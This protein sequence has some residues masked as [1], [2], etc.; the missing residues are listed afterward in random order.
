MYKI[1]ILLVIWLYFFMYLYYNINID[2]T[3]IETPK[4]INVEIINEEIIT[5]TIIKKNIET[6]YIVIKILL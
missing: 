3:A 6:L 1:T 4:T 5:P 2:M